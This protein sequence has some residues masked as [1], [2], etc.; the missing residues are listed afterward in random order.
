MLPA[1]QCQ[2]IRSAQAA[3]GM[4]T[5]IGQGSLWHV[6]SHCVATM[7]QFAVESRGKHSA[8]KGLSHGSL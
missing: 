5:A 7:A 1:V 8:M 2:A 6:H 4:Y 3:Y